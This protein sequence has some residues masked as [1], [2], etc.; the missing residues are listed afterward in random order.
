MPSQLLPA[1][2]GAQPLPGLFAIATCD[3]ER[4]RQLGDISVTR[5][6][7][8]CE[9]FVPSNDDDLRDNTHDARCHRRSPMFFVTELH[10]VVWHGR[11]T[12]CR[13]GEA[14]SIVCTIGFYDVVGRTM[15]CWLC[16]CQSRSALVENDCWHSRQLKNDTSMARSLLL[17]VWASSSSS[18]STSSRPYSSSLPP[19]RS[20]LLSSILG[21]GSVTLLLAEATPDRCDAS[22]CA[23]AYR[24]TVRNAPALHTTWVTR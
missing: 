7:L 13:I 3:C 12:T 17:D 6:V 20:S 15:L 5:Q 21:D 9:W 23:D 14:R 8:G 16:R 11:H 2:D 10:R 1:Y 18:G 24:D 4:Q 22:G 19:S